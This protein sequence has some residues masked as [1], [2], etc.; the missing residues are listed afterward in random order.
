MGCIST[1]LLAIGVAILL[2]TGALPVSGVGFL[3]V[4][5]AVMLVLARWSDRWRSP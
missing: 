1:T 4:I 5:I 3:L 2:A